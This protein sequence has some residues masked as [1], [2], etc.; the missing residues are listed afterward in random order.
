M[1]K[2]G[3]G[4]DPVGKVSGG[5]FAAVGKAGLVGFREPLFLA[6]G[7]SEETALPAEYVFLL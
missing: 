6:L 1:T 5:L 7:M 4:L 2:D 3:S